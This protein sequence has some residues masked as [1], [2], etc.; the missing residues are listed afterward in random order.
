M[1]ADVSGWAHTLVGPFTLQ[2]VHVRVCVQL[3]VCKCCTFIRHKMKYSVTSNLEGP[4]RLPQTHQLMS[5]PLAAP[6]VHLVPVQWR[7]QFC[8]DSLRSISCSGWVHLQ[9]CTS[10]CTLQPGGGPPP[11]FPSG[12]WEGSAAASEDP[13]QQQQPVVVSHTTLQDSIENMYCKQ[14]S[15]HVCITGW[16]TGQI[17]PTFLSWVEF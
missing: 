12:L 1:W 13:E 3:L 7:F 8:W 11:H 14:K 9:T 2:R 4:S 17:S 16:T 15:P 10:V 5:G 6:R